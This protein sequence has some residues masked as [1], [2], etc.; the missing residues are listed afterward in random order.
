M[1]T[2]GGDATNRWLTTN[3]DWCAGVDNSDSGA[4]KIAATY[5]PDTNT[6]LRIDKTTYR[7]DFSGPI[8]LPSFTVGTL[9]SAAYDGGLIYV[10][11][12]SGGEVP[13]FCDGT[14]FRRVTDRAVVS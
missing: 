9:P 7:A 12:E 3:G 1:W 11:D 13:A 14:N 10:T 2:L 6:A 8:K 5:V 4:F